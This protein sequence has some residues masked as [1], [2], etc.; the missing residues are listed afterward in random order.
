MEIVKQNNIESQIFIIRGLQVMLDRDL[1]LLYEIPT[2]AL[3]QA[4]KRNLERFPEKF[5]FQMTAHECEYW[6]SQIVTSNPDK[7]RS[8]FVT[9]KLIF[10]VP[11]W[12]LKKLE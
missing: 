6:K 7:W 2:K 3:N 4:V 5:M 10:K 9:S 8:Q 1:S 11:K 12:H